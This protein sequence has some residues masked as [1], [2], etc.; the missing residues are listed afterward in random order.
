MK[1]SG[2]GRIFYFRER[3]QKQLFPSR[4][5]RRVLKY[6]LRVMKKYLVY[7]RMLDPIIIFI[8]HEILLS[9]FFDE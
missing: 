4:V 5:A 9:T 6:M 8:L 3:K 1:S 2:K 7:K